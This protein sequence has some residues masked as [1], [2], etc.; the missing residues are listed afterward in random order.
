M[1]QPWLSPANLEI[2]AE[3]IHR[4]GAALDNCWGFVDGTVQP[5]CRPGSNQRIL[6]NGHKRVH[7]IKFQAVS[8]PNGLCA[9][10]SGPFE[11][12]KHDSSMLYD[13]GLLFQL[14]QHSFSRNGNVLC[15]YGDPAYPVRPQ[16]MS[17]FGNPHLTADQKAWN[18][19][20]SSVR[21]SVEWLFG[22]IKNYFKFLDFKKNLKIQLSAVG[23][24]FVVCTI[25]QN[26]RSCLYGS[27]TS[28]SFEI[29]PPTLI[30]YFV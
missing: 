2:Y 10:L 24:S 12:K 6:Y 15:V 20:M 7:A 25:L 11:G 8:A 18:K 13:S 9:H 30:Q 14:Q 19:S 21:V 1:N 23:K 5:V 27:V 22:D 16:L 28:R 3:K 29:E 17:P 26:A 4:K